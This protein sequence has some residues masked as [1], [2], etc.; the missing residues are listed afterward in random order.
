MMQHGHG[1]GHDREQKH[2]HKP[3]PQHIRKLV[4]AEDMLPAEM[5]NCLLVSSWLAAWPAAKAA[6]TMEAVG[7]CI[8]ANLDRTERGADGDTLRAAVKSAEESTRLPLQRVIGKKASAM[9]CERCTMILGALSM[10]G[11]AR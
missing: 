7:A 10:Q 4:T 11:R 2:M 8:L 3:S 5:T 6:S 9:S 1:P